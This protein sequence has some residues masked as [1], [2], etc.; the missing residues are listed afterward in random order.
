MQNRDE[1][2][3]PGM[4]ARASGGECKPRGRAVLDSH[5]RAGGDEPHGLPPLPGLE[6][7]PVFWGIIR[8]VP[9][10]PS[11]LLGGGGVFFYTACRLK[12]VFHVFASP[13]EMGG[14]LSAAGT[15]GPVL[16]LFPFPHISH[17]SV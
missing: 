13:K 1:E 16:S 12:G 17:G 6:M 4:A 9:R 10:I 5:F 15:S 14:Q 11:P 2:T 7:S 3:S 8:V